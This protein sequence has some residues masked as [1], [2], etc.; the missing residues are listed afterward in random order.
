ML[1]MVS[2]ELRGNEN[3][4]CTS[5]SRLKF[6]IPGFGGQL[7]KY[8]KELSCPPNFRGHKD[9]SVSQQLN[10]ICADELL[11]RTQLSWA[12]LFSAVITPTLNSAPW[13]SA[14]FLE[15]QPRHGNHHQPAQYCQGAHAQEC[16]YQSAPAGTLC[17]HTHT[18]I[19]T[20]CKVVIVFN[21]TTHTHTL[22][23]WIVVEEEA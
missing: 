17:G 13:C 7:T 6:L 5:N 8:L 18:N 22:D 4:S 19:Y 10:P 1:W 15:N 11:Q 12:N 21:K 3:Y 2:W 23:E 16:S 9:T 20:Y 14:F